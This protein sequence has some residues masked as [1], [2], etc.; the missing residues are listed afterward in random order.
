VVLGEGKLLRKTVFGITVSLLIM[1]MLTLA[2]NI[3]P[4]KAEPRTWTVD[5]DG[6]ADFHTIQEA[7]NAASLG[8]TI[9]VYNGTYYENVVVNKTVTLIGE[10]RSTTFIDGRRLGTVVNITANNVVISHF[11]MQ[12]GGNNSFDQYPASGINVLSTNTTISDNNVIDNCIGIL[13]L[14]SNDNKIVNNFVGDN[15]EG[16]LI[17]ASNNN[18]LKSN[19]IAN[20]TYNFGV[21][22]SS[23][24]GYP[25]IEGLGVI[26]NIDTSNT[27]DGKPIYYLVNQS[28]KEIPTDAGFVAAVY[29]KNI[30]VRNL[31][32]TRNCEGVLF[33]YTKDSL[34]E[35]VNALNNG[36]GIVLTD[37]SSNNTIRRNAVSNNGFGILLS[38][39][40]YDNFI[41]N[42]SAMSNGDAIYVLGADGNVIFS[43]TLCSNGIGLYC[44]EESSYNTFANNNVKNN[45]EAVHIYWSSDNNFYHNNFANNTVE[46][47]VE[48]FM[49]PNNVWDD[50]YPSGGNFWSDYTDVDLCYGPYQ[51]QTGSDG[52]WDHPYIIN[53]NNVDW[54]PL[55][56]PWTL[57]STY[58]QGID[59]SHHQG[60]INWSKV[61]GAGYRFAFVKATGGVSFTDPNFTANMEQAGQAGLIVGAYHFA[62][63]EYNDAV[64]EAQHFLSVAGNYM[65]TGYLRPILDLEDDPKENSY[66]Y[67]M[68]KD[69]LT[70]WIHTW[71]NTVKSE[72]GIEP[73]IYTGWYARMGDYLDASIAQYDLWIADWTYDPTISPDTGIW[74]SWDFWQYSNNGSVPGIAGDVDLDLDLFNGYMYRLYDVFT[75]PNVKVFNVVWGNKTY[76]IIVYSNSTV[77]HLVFNQTSAQISFNITGSHGSQGYCNIT[78]PKDL[79]KGPWTYTMDGETPSVIDI[80]EDE[81][82]THSFIYFTYIHLSTFRITIQGAWA[83]PEFPSTIILPLFMLTTLIVTVLL[84]KKRKKPQLP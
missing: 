55:V 65:R 74:D 8:D 5:D 80:S 47:Y 21:A 78:I 26:H 60:S 28:D 33:C 35:N 20:N 43:N 59:I 76:P 22:P 4:V 25:L 64:S 83:V 79:L 15:F 10:H 56:N 11:T 82:A 27:V 51:N 14:R 77:T 54:Y 3:Q 53:E 72:T 57:I 36:M 70:N 67:R 44:E 24:G 46:V 38:F 50:G 6:S 18:T 71:M 37:G 40:S 41:V 7:I 52:I 62:Y 61:Y 49:S 16:V 45:S 23:F 48:G 2:F 63:P 66:P 29:S 9:F 31:N 1:S 68:G 17:S 81:N 58:V 34:I 12:K 42:N 69:N 32:L 39:D 30:A 84:K 13:V 19:K 73:F 75:I